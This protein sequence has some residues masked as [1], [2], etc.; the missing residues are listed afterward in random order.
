MANTGRNGHTVN[1]IHTNNVE[2]DDR[3][4]IYIADRAGTGMHI[5]KLTGQAAGAAVGNDE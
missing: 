1:A 4:L 5:I 3:G 2:V